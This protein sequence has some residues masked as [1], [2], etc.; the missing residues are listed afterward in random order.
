MEAIGKFFTGLIM[1]IITTILSG[2]LLVKLWDWF[3]L[4]VFEIKQITLIQAIGLTFFIS[5]F[6][7]TIDYTKSQELTWSKFVE[8]FFTSIILYGILFLLGY[9]IHL[10]Y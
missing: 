5:C 3:L 1:L 10:L 8:K 9:I 2:F 6:I 7:K 4:P